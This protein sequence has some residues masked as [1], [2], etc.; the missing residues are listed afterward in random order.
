MS[1]LTHSESTPRPDAGFDI[2]AMRRDREAGTPGDWWSFVSGE[3][4]PSV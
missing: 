3:L 2:E 1:R 4:A